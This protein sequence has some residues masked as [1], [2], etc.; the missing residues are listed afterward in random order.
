VFKI[1]K[2]LQN[3]SHTVLKIIKISVNYWSVFMVS[4]VKR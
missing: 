3:Q 4:K 2:L 1:N